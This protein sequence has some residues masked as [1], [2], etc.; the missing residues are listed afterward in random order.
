METGHY[1][2]PTQFSYIEVG[3]FKRSDK[4]DTVRLT[5]PPHW[6]KEGLLWLRDKLG[7]VIDEMDKPKPEWTHAVFNGDCIS[8]HLTSGKLYPI[9]NLKGNC[10]EMLD[11]EGYERVCLIKGC[12]LLGGGNWTLVNL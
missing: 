11:D 9:Y 10:F 8:A 1:S 3:S 12:G 5:I 7:E 2:A 6:D 4:G